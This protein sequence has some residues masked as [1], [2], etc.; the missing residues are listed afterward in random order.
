MCSSDLPASPE[1]GRVYEFREVSG[2]TATVTIKS[3][4][5]NI[6][7]VTGTTGVTLVSAGYGSATAVFSGTEW[8]VLY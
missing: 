4:A 6:N 8:F 2:V 7:G 1:T 5:H 3:S